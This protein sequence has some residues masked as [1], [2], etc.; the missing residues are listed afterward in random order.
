MN[1]YARSAL[2]A[3]LSIVATGRVSQTLAAN[4]SWNLTSGSWSVGSN[5]TPNGGPP[6]GTDTAW[7]VDGGTA[8]DNL[9]SG[10]CSTLYLGGALSGTVV[11]VSGGSLGLA[12]NGEIVGYTGVGT[13]TQSGG[14]NEATG[15]IVL[16]DNVG[17]SGSYNLSGGTLAA[18]SEYV[19][20]SYIGMITQT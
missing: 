9:P 20:N 16:G 13:F 5:W 2:I 14:T 18:A 10:N 19:G 6:L 4:Y 7:V 17:S 1:R 11:L 15:G 3:A 12:A 8:T